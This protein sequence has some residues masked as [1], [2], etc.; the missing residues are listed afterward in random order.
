MC[1]RII[2]KA[3]SDLRL[4]KLQS[5]RG[6]I[7]ALSAFSLHREIVQCFRADNIARV[8]S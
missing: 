1:L 2:K 8:I 4:R 6:L 7:F 5:V 3:N